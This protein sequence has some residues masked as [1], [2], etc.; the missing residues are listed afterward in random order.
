MEW[1]GEVVWGASMLWARVSRNGN[2]ANTSASAGGADGFAA[3]VAGVCGAPVG[4]CSGFGSISWRRPRS[5]RHLTWPPAILSPI[6]AERVKRGSCNGFSGCWVEKRTPQRC[7]PTFRVFRVFRGF[8]RKWGEIVVAS[9]I[10]SAIFRI[11]FLRQNA[12]N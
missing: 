1:T 11:P 9:R 7:V 5:V 10:W 12:D 8:I 3:A 6:E 2:R 4:A